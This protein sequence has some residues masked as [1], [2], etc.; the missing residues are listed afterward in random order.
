VLTRFIQDAPAPETLMRALELLN[1]LAAL[2]D[3]GNITALGKLIAAFPVEPQVITFDSIHMD[4]LMIAQLA[5]MLV[6]SP[7]FKCSN[8]VLTIVAMLSGKLS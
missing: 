7:E 8:E 2:D 3:D 1:Y 4:I 6:S 5:K